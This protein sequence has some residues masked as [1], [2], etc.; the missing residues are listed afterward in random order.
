M[1]DE[2]ENY[3]K[4]AALQQLADLGS[5][6]R[7]GISAVEDDKKLKQHQRFQPELPHGFGKPFPQ[8]QG[9]DQ[10]KKEFLNAWSNLHTIVGDTKEELS[11]IMGGQSHRSKLNNDLLHSW[12]GSQDPPPQQHRGPKPGKPLPKMGYKPVYKS[13]SKPPP[14]SRVPPTVRSPLTARATP[15]AK[16]SAPKSSPAAKPSPAPKQSAFKAS[17]FKASPAGKKSPAPK[18][19][20]G[21]KPSPAGK[22]PPAPRPSQASKPSPSL[23]ASPT[24]KQLPA[25]RPQPA[26]TQGRRR[27]E[28]TG[29]NLPQPQ[30]SSA[31]FQPRRHHEEDL[32]TFDSPPSANSRHKSPVKVYQSASMC[33]LMEID[34]GEMLTNKPT[35]TGRNAS[36]FA[37]PGSYDKAKPQKGSTENAQTSGL[38][39]SK[40]ATVDD[41]SVTEGSIGKAATQNNSNTIDFW[42]EA[43]PRSVKGIIKEKA[44]SSSAEKGPE[45]LAKSRW[46]H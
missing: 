34:D 41:D 33:D 1:D 9:E 18:P 12:V 7:D 32:L 43:L 20:Q 6:R 16:P 13:A 31:A 11:S 30:T 17:A 42:Q 2:E 15:A 4:Q 40:Y 39:A 38:M 28:L 44:G 23:K 27:V 29:Y 25:S 5:L 37:P 26:S 22:K 46:A 35:M 14:Y 10:D 8:P 21:P 19:S 24:L 36:N 45:P 3:C